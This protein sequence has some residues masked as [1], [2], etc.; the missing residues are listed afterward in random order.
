MKNTKSL[1]ARCIAKSMGLPEI[2]SIVNE[3]NEEQITSGIYDASVQK[4]SPIILV[5]K[6]CKVIENRE[7]FQNGKMSKKDIYNL[8]VEATKKNP[9][10]NQKLGGS[11]RFATSFVNSLNEGIFSKKE[12]APEST[13]NRGARPLELSK[14][15][16]GK[17]SVKAYSREEDKFIGRHDQFHQGPNEEE[18]AMANKIVKSLKRDGNL[19]KVLKSD[20]NA[21][22][23]P[24][25]KS[26]SG[27]NIEIYFDG[28]SSNKENKY[29]EGEPDVE[30]ADDGSD[31]YKLTASRDNSSRRSRRMNENNVSNSL[32]PIVD[33]F[34]KDVAQMCDLGLTYTDISEV[35]EDAIP[36]LKKLAARSRVAIIAGD[37]EA[38]EDCAEQAVKLIKGDNMEESRDYR[39][40]LRAMR[41]AIDIE[42]FCLD[43]CD[44]NID[45]DEETIEAIERFCML[46]DWEIQP[47]D[48]IKTTYVN[49]AN[50]KKGILTIKTTQGV[51]SY[52]I[53]NDCLVDDPLAELIDEEP[54]DDAYYDEM[55]ESTKEACA[56][57]MAEASRA[58]N[59][60]RRIAEARKRI[61][62]KKA[63][64]ERVKKG[65][66]RVR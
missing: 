4:V 64:K 40:N 63:L 10:V 65:Y 29:G 35:R 37:E 3:L 57:R 16:S 45:Q 42:E 5:S 6:L 53:N 25:A 2:V 27:R 8:V 21:D 44:D 22:I 52:D 32:P 23:I 39:R 12:E 11:T 7:D 28:N 62:E 9:I 61:A 34:L 20:S 17:I 19:D 24:S 58:R 56:R 41:E 47:S 13:Y 43:D 38:F 1:S 14:T 31:E 48:V 60:A 49:V 36:E 30:Y 54:W 26:K 18:L 15:D 51:Y 66:R 59:R 55:D 50:F 46:M 33:A